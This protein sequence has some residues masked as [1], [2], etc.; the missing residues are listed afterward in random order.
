HD[1]EGNMAGQ[2]PRQMIDQV[3]RLCGV[4]SSAILGKVRRS[5]VSTARKFVCLALSRFLG[6]TNSTIAHYIEKD[7]STISYSL[8]IVE[9]EIQ[10]SRHLNK[11]WN[12]IC[13]QLGM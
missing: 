1:D 7:P 13:S 12:W 8:K 2:N 6:L 9:E 5:D 11:Q 3:A 10:T 4:S